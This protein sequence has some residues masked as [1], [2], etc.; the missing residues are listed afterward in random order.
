M[1]GQK[2]N[3][4]NGDLTLIQ[5][6]IREEPGAWQKFLQR[7]TDLVYSYCSSVFLD[8]EVEA[9]YLEVLRRIRSDNCAV[10]R[11]FS[12]RAAFS[13]FLSLQLRELLACRIL[14]LFKENPDRAWAAFQRCFKELLDPLKTRSEDLY[15]EICLK[16]IDKNY[17]RIVS[18]HG[19]GS[20]SGY[21]RRVLDNLCLDLLRESEGRRRLPE[22]VQRLPALEQEIYRQLH[23]RGCSEKELT[24]IL[25][26]E[27]GNAYEPARIEEALA[28]V[29]NV[30]GR[31]RDAPIREVL[32]AF[33]DND[34]DGK[35]KEVPDSNY[36]PES[37]LLDA[38]Q[39]RS[40]EQYFAA[41]KEALAGL[42]A[43]LALYIRLRFYS[44]PP[45]SPRQIARLMGRSE[46]EIYRTRQDA[47]SILKATLKAK[48]VEENSNLSVWRKIDGLPKR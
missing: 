12:G 14:Q 18:F 39:E 36:S 40:K 16:L 32:L 7:Y 25:R 11:A 20:F 45:K 48:G 34:L 13:T 35:E 21:V 38:E 27:E 44:D 24:E 37:L 43:E 1:R 26:D 4:Q 15:Q 22:A 47:I 6:V 33:T 29:R 8:V 17:R 46:R 9:A 31:R 19:R 2:G 10:L 42:P 5:D 30:Q 41:L 23:W 3:E 28:Q